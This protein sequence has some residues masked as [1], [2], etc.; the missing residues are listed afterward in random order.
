MRQ[1]VLSCVVALVVGMAAAVQG[2]QT[3]DFS[4]R[5]FD[6][7]TKGGIENLQVRFAPPR[8]SRLPVRIATTDRNGGFRF[9]DLVRGPY[10]L[11]ISQGPHIL[12]R[13]EV[14]ATKIS[15]LDVPLRRRQTSE[16]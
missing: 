8:N 2:Q 14:D 13:A 5:V 4:G 7:A 1:V 16:P 15:R 10:L 3:V 12:H 11:E 6:A 9:P